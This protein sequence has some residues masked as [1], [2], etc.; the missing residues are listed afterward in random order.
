VALAG[1]ARDTAPTKRRRGARAPDWGP[2]R[3][4]RKAPSFRVR[5]TACLPPRQSCGC[6]RSAPRTGRRETTTLPFATSP[7]EARWTNLL[8]ACSEVHESV[9]AW[10]APGDVQGE[11]AATDEASRPSGVLIFDNARWSSRNAVG[12]QTATAAGSRSC[13]LIRNGVVCYCQ[14]SAEHSSH[15]NCSLTVRL[16]G[17]VV[18][19][20]K[21]HFRS[22]CSWDVDLTEQARLDPTWCRAAPARVWVATYS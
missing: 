21:E 13:S 9:A 6:D 1:R 18:A 16:R 3:A 10:R 8:R 5:V 20:S 14:W 12:A 22:R 7:V 19:N 4:E 15:K 17:D 2:E 11:P